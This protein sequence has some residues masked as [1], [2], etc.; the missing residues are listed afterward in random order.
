[1]TTSQG[2]EIVLIG[3]YAEDGPLNDVWRFNSRTSTWSEIE[4]TSSSSLNPLP[5][6]EFAGC[7]LGEQVL[8][9][10]GM[11]YDNEQ[12]LILND[13]W[14][15]RGTNWSLLAEECPCAERAGHVCVAIDADRMLVHGGECMGTIFDD[16]WLFTASTNAWLRI[17]PAAAVAAEAGALSSTS[18]PAGRAA[19]SACYCPEISSIAIFGG[20]SSAAMHYFND[21]WLLPVTTA[22]VGNQWTL[23]TF[24]GIAPSPRDLPGL[25]CV[26]EKLIVMGGFGLSEVEHLDEEEESTLGGG[27]GSGGG[28]G[29]AQEESASTDLAAISLE[30]EGGGASVSTT[31]AAS[32][33]ENEEVKKSQASDVAKKTEEEGEDGEE[34]EDDDD[35]EMQYLSDTWLVNIKSPFTTEEINIADL[36]AV[37]EQQAAAAAGG[38]EPE[39]EQEQEAPIA[40]R[41]CKM[42]VTSRGM[43]LAFGGFDGESFS[44]ETELI[45]FAKTI[46]RVE[47]KVGDA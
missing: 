45:D 4:I 42:V 39:E 26:N 9:F 2:D 17:S 6:L 36:L 5:R 13:L 3:G 20:Y 44:G 15:L 35:V 23:V 7:A 12:V 32:A 24:D 31:A 21:L 10:G 34:E 38:G 28:G 1:M 43:V 27:G 8:V 40:R 37:D 47:A 25:V 41:G 46:T 33:P 16:L 30:E 19:H 11:Q 18:W 22:G 29:E 14:T